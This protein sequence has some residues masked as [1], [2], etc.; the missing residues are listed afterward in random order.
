MSIRA[1]SNNQASMLVTRSKGTSKQPHNAIEDVQQQDIK[2][3]CSNPLY[4]S[5]IRVQDR[6]C[7]DKTGSPIGSVSCRSCWLL[8]RHPA[9]PNQYHL[10]EGTLSCKKGLGTLIYLFLFVVLLCR[11]I[12]VTYSFPLDQRHCWDANPKRDVW[13]SGNATKINP[14]QGYV[15]A[16]ESCLGDPSGE[17][18]VS[19]WL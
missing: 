6:Y 15:S 19:I 2:L 1:H 7:L 11:S 16:T 13:F 17:F 4:D 18:T 5:I 12:W 10:H 9:T 14:R 3:N 8:L